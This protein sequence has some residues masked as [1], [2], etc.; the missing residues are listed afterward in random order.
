MTETAE[1]AAVRAVIEDRIDAIHAGDAER[2]N[3]CLAEDVVAFEAVPPLAI[4]GEAV[5]D[6]EVTRAWLTM[7]EEP[8][9]I[10]VRDLVIHASDDVAF[11]HALHH[12]TGRRPDGTSV[13]FWLRSTLGL[14]RIGGEWKI[15]HAHGSVP[16]HIDGSYRAALD[17]QPD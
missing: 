17:L 8:P 4:S 13:D 3:A 15:V 6:V 5:C 11:A 1:Q 10:E 12:L 14:K 16:F 2:T 9:R 7:Y